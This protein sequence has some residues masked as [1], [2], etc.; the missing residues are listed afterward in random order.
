[1]NQRSRY[2]GSI[3]AVRPGCPAA[4]GRG[5]IMRWHSGHEENGVRAVSE[6]T[7]PGHD[8]ADSETANAPSHALITPHISGQIAVLA[9][10]YPLVF[11]LW[12]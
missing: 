2:S 6:A 3:N 7:R 9:S 1:M 4:N 5:G 11:G 12:E 8:A 10:L